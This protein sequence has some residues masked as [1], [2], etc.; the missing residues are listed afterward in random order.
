MLVPTWA[1]LSAG[2]KAFCRAVA[3]GCRDAKAIAAYLGKKPNYVSKYKQR[4]L[5]QGVV[6]QDPY[7]RIGFCLPAF[8][9]FV[10]RME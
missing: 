3:D 4:L 10:G 2:D 6:E 7:A 9:A 8:E 5:E 1:S